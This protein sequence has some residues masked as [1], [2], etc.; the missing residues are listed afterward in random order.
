MIT[1]Y[2]NVMTKVSVLVI[3]MKS[4]FFFCMKRELTA[5]IFLPITC[6]PVRKLI[7]LL[8]ADKYVP[9]GREGNVLVICP[10]NRLARYLQGHINHDLDDSNSGQAHPATT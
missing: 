7:L 8:I 1:C 5:K 6:L 4:L 9:R 2:K 10:G 3:P